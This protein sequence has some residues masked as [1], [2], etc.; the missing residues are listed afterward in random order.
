MLIS[1]VKLSEIRSLDATA[2]PRLVKNIKNIK[3]NN[4]LHLIYSPPIKI[5]NIINLHIYKILQHIAYLT[6]PILK[7]S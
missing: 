2:D 3:I 4:I 7:N 6:T 1:D 5:A